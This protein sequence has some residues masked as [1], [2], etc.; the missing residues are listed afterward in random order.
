MSGEIHM[1]AAL[2]P[3][4]ECYFARY[5]KKLSET[6]WAIVDVSLEKY[7]P[8]PSINFRRRP[9]GCFIQFMPQEGFSKITWV[10]H[11]EAD[12]RDLNSTFKD[13]IKS[14]FAFG[15]TR[16]I[17]AMVRQFEYSEILKAKY[18]PP[19]DAVKVIGEGGRRSM[20][21]LGDRM[22]RTFCSEINGSKRNQWFRL[23]GEP[24]D[25]T[26]DVRLAIREHA[27][28]AGK[29]LATTLVFAASQW[30]PIT[31]RLLFD[32]LRDAE[33]RTD[34]DV[35]A[36]GLCVQE[37]S[38]IVKGKDS[39][40]RVSLMQ[41]TD[42]LDTYVINYIQESYT[43]ITGSYVVYAPIDEPAVTALLEGGDPDMVGILPSG[44]SILPQE[45]PKDDGP[46]SGV[47]SILTASFNIV[48]YGS[49]KSH[50]PPQSLAVIKKIL[51]ETF[52]AIKSFVF[53]EDSDDD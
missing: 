26:E 38:Y 49:N 21:K 53:N 41:V 42:E 28:E 48:D 24:F 52:K 18:W 23:P 14:S 13:L 9:S 37:L 3:G 12:Y 2:V 43:D 7:F 51:R 47:A 20:L 17:S 4:R 45:I 19:E 34:W 22:I 5:C 15:A 31:P 46:H 25:D 36:R 44:F 39:A 11:V 30:F 35:L 27:I 50:V 10:E 1:P 16:W 33:S 6:T 32:F 8:H 40:N 29:P